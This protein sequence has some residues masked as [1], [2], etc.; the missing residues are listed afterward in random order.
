MSKKAKA[1]LFTMIFLMIMDIIMHFTTCSTDFSYHLNF[2]ASVLLAFTLGL[3][4]ADT[5][6]FRS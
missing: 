6:R 5:P 3:Y 1:W 2:I 4:V